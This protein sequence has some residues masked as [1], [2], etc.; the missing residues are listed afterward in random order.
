LNPKWL[1]NGGKEAMRAWCNMPT[2]HE[3]GVDPKAL[4]SEVFDAHLASILHKEDNALPFSGPEPPETLQGH[5]L[6]LGESIACMFLGSQK[7]DEQRSAAL[8]EI[9][10]NPLPLPAI[11][12]QAAKYLA[13]SLHQSLLRK[14]GNSPL[15]P[16]TTKLSSIL[17]PGKLLHAHYEYVLKR[18]EM[19][20]AD[21]NDLTNKAT[22]SNIAD[23]KV[24]PQ[25]PA[26]KRRLQE[27][28]AKAG[29]KSKL[30]KFLKVD[31]TRV[32]QWLS[33]SE[34]AREPGAEYALRMLFWVEHPEVQ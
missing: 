21:K 16:F 8:L 1:A 32:S 23:V 9:L 14:V 10:N 11:T 15:P 24:Q 17:E 4:F 6:E 18:A 30:A 33:D 29:S 31:L 19:E 22:S 28:T 5:I 7:S 2:S 34:N 20:S 12:I 3:L 27:A 25:W 13:Q 26:L